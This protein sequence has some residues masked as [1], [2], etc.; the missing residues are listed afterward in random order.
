M[1]KYD[2]K[3]RKYADL[4]Q[5]FVN[6]EGYHYFLKNRPNQQLDFSTKVHILYGAIFE[7]SNLL[8]IRPEQNKSSQVIDDLNQFY[9]G[10]FESEFDL[11]PIHHLT[12]NPDS[13]DDAILESKISPQGIHIIVSE[14]LPVETPQF[15]MDVES[16]FRVGNYGIILP[17]ESSFFSNHMNN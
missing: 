15:F 14:D 6:Y 5:D 8:F 17:K 10:V 9:L 2:E 3:L 12:T 4:F 13:I 1:F 11:E 7:K 16:R